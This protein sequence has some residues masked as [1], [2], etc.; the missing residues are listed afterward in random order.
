MFCKPVHKMTNAQICEI[1]QE[2]GEFLELKGKRRSNPERIFRQYKLFVHWM[3]P[4]TNSSNKNNWPRSKAS[5][6]RSRKRSRNWSK[7]VSWS[8]MK[9]LKQ[10]IPPGL[11]EIAGLPGLDRRKTG[12]LFLKLGVSN[13][14]ELEQACLNDQVSQ[15]R[16][17]NKARQQQILSEIKKFR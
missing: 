14:E 3:L 4:S 2:I 5:A 6:S 7:R 9:K 11:F 15:L 16:G 17:F 13:L 1:L 12:L 8:I 10:S